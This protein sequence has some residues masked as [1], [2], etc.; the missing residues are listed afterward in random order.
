MKTKW[1]IDPM[2][3]EV[4]FRIKHLVIS[5]V[6]GSFGKFSATVETEG[7]NFE[8]AQIHFSADA[9]SISTGNEQR[10]GHLKSPDF[11]DVGQ[12]PTIDF[13]STGIKK[14]GENKF[15]V[16]GNFTMH[17]IS[18]SIQ[19]EA[20]FGG[21]MKDPYGNIKIGFE[22]RGK[23]NRKDFGLHWN[24]ATETGGVV[25]SDEVKIEC[26]VEF[27]KVVPAEKEKVAA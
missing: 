8:T 26:N 1:N 25:V 15:L 19:L 3:S 23:I 24:A 22:V 17:G 14:S 2:H 27:A 11:F 16:T 12:F 21:T 7:D 18:K 20:E 10:D 9:S 5:T 4:Q 13:I 6:T